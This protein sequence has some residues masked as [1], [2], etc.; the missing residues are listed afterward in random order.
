M[1]REEWVTKEDYDAMISHKEAEAQLSDV[2]VVIM[3]FAYLAALATGFIFR[4][5]LKLGTFS[6]ATSTVVVIFALTFLFMIAGTLYHTPKMI[7]AKY[8]MYKR[9]EFVT[10]KFFVSE[11]SY[12]HDS[13]YSIIRLTNI[14]KMVANINV[15]HAPVSYLPNGEID[16]ATTTRATSY[17]EK[18]IRGDI[19]AMKISTH[20]EIINSLIP[21]YIICFCLAFLVG[22][23]W[24]WR[25]HFWEIKN[26]P[27]NYFVNL[28]TRIFSLVFWGSII[29]LLG[30]I[31]FS[32]VLGRSVSLFGEHSIVTVIVWGSWS[33][34][35]TVFWQIKSRAFAP[36][37][38]LHKLK[39]AVKEGDSEAMLHL[40]EAYIEG[41]GVG[42]NYR[43][44]Y[45][46]LSKVATEGNI[47]AQYKLGLLYCSGSGVAED[48]SRA[49]HLFTAAA[50]GGEADA[51][52]TLYCLFSTGKYVEQDHIQ[53]SFW[54]NEMQKS[55]DVNHEL[56]TFKLGMNL[57]MSEQIRWDKDH[58]DECLEVGS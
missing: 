58:A 8:D 14:D 15:Y 28:L 13:V 19:R 53:A 24:F 12:K 25:S 16:L 27:Y 39:V 33:L 54:L 32:A 4:M 41:F 44:A 48:I 11:Q 38:D 9:I 57:D 34:V 21:I 50:Q 10:D 55:M 18:M 47:I 49:V 26:M 30:F 42:T 7:Q 40:A 3:F 1:L 46:L 36:P 23:G 51:Q 43:K 22:L 37:N 29:S 31:T 6:R 17:E 52:Y 35:A 2:H 56:R 20:N 45:K 5:C